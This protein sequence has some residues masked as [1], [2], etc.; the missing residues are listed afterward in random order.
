MEGTFMKHFKPNLTILLVL[1]SA[2]A[3]FWGCEPEKK[4]DSTTTAALLLAATSSGGDCVVNTT[5]KSPAN[6][7]VTDL[8]VSGTSKTG[9]VSRIGSIPIVGHQTS[10]IKFTV[11]S[12]TTVTLTG[13]AFAILYKA[14]NCPLAASSALA[15]NTGFT[16]NAA[17]SNSEFP[18]SHK[19]VTSSSTVISTTGTYY[20]FFYAIPSR[21]Q[22]A[23]LRYVISP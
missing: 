23:T 19:V 1:F 7:F 9:T 5:G 18:T 2:S 20:Y 15:Y 10:V 4:D 13:N 21:G 22:A 16:T 11:S 17:D 14:E 6:T 12:T 8:T 3:F